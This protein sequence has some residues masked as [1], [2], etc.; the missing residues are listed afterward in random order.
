VKL[1]GGQCQR[2]AIA[3]A[4]L[5]ALQIPILDQATS[6]LDMESEQLILASRAV[7][8]AGRTT[9]VIA[10]RL[11]TIRR[12]DLILVMDDG[13]VVERG[14]H[15][16]LMDARGGYHRMVLRQMEFPGENGEAMWR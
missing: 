4:L 7:L 12:A 11:S 1:S 8:L 9:F 3:R 14:T 16:E 2:L 15:E 13:L 6:V 5:A 10:R